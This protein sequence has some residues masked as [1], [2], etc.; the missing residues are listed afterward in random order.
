MAQAS[1]PTPLPTIEITK[2][3]IEWAISNAAAGKASGP[4]GIANE[5]LQATATIA[6]DTLLWLFNACLRTGHYPTPF[7]HSRTIPLRKPGK[8]DYTKVDNYRPI[9]LLST[10]GKVLES[11]LAERLSC[12]AEEHGL[13]PPTHLGGR[14][15]ISRDMAIH[16]MTERIIAAKNKKHQASMLLLDVSGAFDNVSHQRLLHNLRKRKICGATVNLLAS[17]VTGR[18]TS[19][20]VSGEGFDMPTPTGIP[21]GSPLSPILYLFYNA[22]LVASLNTTIA[23]PDGR[24]LGR[25]WTAGWI[26]DVAILADVPNPLNVPYVLQRAH[27]ITEDWARLHASKFAPHKY[28]LVHFR[29]KHRPAVTMGATEVKPTAT[30]KYLGVIYDEDLNWKPQQQYAIKLARQRLSALNSIAASAWGPNINDL[31][32]IYTACIRP[33]MLQVA[34]AWAPARCYEGTE[35]ARAGQPV[36]RALASIQKLAAKHIS[37]GLFTTAMEAQNIELHLEPIDLALA[38]AAMKQAASLISNPKYGDMVRGV[39]GSG[40]LKSPLSRAIIELEK[41]GIRPQQIETPRPFA[42]RPWEDP[43]EGEIPEDPLSAMIEHERVWVQEGAICIYTDGSGYE[44][45]VGA[46]AVSQQLGVELISY[47]GPETAA[48]VYMGELAGIKMAL[49]IAR[50]MVHYNMPFFIFSDNQSAIKA[51]RRPN[52]RAPPKLVTEILELHR[53]LKGLAERNVSVHL[54]WLPAHRGIPGNEAADAAAKRA[55]QL[56]KQLRVP[57]TG[58]PLPLAKAKAAV[59]Q[60]TQDQWAHRWEHSAHGH[61]LR[62]WQPAPDRRTLS[63][64]SNLTRRQASLLFQKRTGKNP[65]NAYIY[66]I[67]RV[68]SPGCPCGAP[69]QDVNHVLFDCPYLDEQRDA[70]LWARTSTRDLGTILED[71]TLSKT[72]TALAV[73][74]GFLRGLGRSHGFVP[75]EPPDHG[76]PEG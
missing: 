27:Q 63:R 62:H 53:E 14:K 46:S 54:R 71:V 30:A 29:T 2:G 75:K 6:S 21:Q 48:T 12:C 41:L 11:I 35:Q 60:R 50:D 26:D 55:A 34:C 67:G 42:I 37:G 1:Y 33:L 74:S 57:E 13:L 5:A 23:A 65:Q 68:D 70:E 10:V 49:Q 69:K 59:H 19:L 52:R 25:L 4:D 45:H 20:D 8:G 61:Q 39:A 18:S 22:D 76:R 7:K 9:A 43:P 31:R 16:A 72:A 24:L 47:L 32:R 44:G 51:L 15:G 56:G 66:T 36:L 58:L 64:Y 38:D 40:T 73:N 17:Y 28:Q 3:E